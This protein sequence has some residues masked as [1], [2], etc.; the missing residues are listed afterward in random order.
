LRKLVVV[1]GGRPRDRLT[2]QKR[3]LAPTAIIAG[4]QKTKR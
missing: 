3:E 4:I 2:G 1:T